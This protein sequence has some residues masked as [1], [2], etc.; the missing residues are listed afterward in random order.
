MVIARSR[1]SGACPRWSASRRRH[2]D[3]KNLTLLDTCDRS[4]LAG[5]LSRGA[6]RRDMLRLLLSMGLA[7]ASAGGL[8]SVATKAH[9]QSPKKGGRVRAAV[10]S[11]STGDT[12]DP[13]KG[14]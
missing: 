1:T 9:A 6:S 13:A 5:A 2:M 12:L 4:R 8:L 10:S 3:D 11:S 7:T 14:A